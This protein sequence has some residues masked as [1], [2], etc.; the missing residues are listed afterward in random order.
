MMPKK[1]LVIGGSGFIGSNLVS[2]LATHGIQTTVPVRRRE[3]CRH[4][5]LLPGVDLIVADVRN[6]MDLEEMMTGTDAVI[7]LAG[8]LHDR[9]SRAPY[10]RNF[11]AV[12][13]ELPE[14]ILAAMR[15]TGVRRLLHMS[16]I[17]ADENAP[18]EFYRS[19]AAGDAVVLGASDELDV[20]VFR[21]SI[22]FGSND[23][24]LNFFALLMKLSPVLPLACGQ[25]RFQPVYVGD[26]AEAMIKTF[27]LP[28]TF[29]KIYE[30]GGPRT[31]TLRQLVEYAGELTGHRRLIIALPDIL[32][33]L[34]A[35][36]FGL[37]PNPP[38]S[39]DTLRSLRVDNLANG[40]QNLPFW[41]PQ[42]MEAVVP[43]YLTANTSKARLSE[44]RSRRSSNS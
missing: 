39:P 4:L 23:S 35:K 1:V 24:F 21:P 29:G 27:D 42:P 2:R 9:D 8:I 10:G 34:Q 19:K 22:V 41:Q 18:S 17:G 25:T 20:T 7:N 3:R 12:H 6:P 16:T 26:I 31:Y 28:D 32:A 14:K 13:V 43:T 36:V 37:L 15:R 11:A 30:L 40:H 44:Y 38:I 5:A 33:R